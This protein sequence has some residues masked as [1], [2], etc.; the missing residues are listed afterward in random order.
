L[1]LKPEQVLAIVVT[2]W[3][4]AI[5]AFF[6]IQ[7]QIATVADRQITAAEKTRTEAAVN[8]GETERRITDRL[9]SL[10]K[11]IEARAIADRAIERGRG[12]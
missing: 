5:G 8:L 10:E 11:L 9:I 12:R 3:V 1:N 7:N 2:L 4:A 6:Y